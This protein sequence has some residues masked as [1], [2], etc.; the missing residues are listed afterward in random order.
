MATKNLTTP[1]STQTTNNN[2][3]SST[4]SQTTTT[5]AARTRLRVLYD[6]E[7]ETKG[8][9]VHI[10]K[11]ER[12]LLLNKT[13]NDWWQ[14]VRPDDCT[15]NY[16]GFY[17][18]ENSTFYVPSGYVV[19]EPQ[20][21]DTTRFYVDKDKMFKQE[22]SQ[23]SKDQSA[24]KEDAKEGSKDGSGSRK[25][26][27]SFRSVMRKL[28]GTSSTSNSDKDSLGSN[29]NKPAKPAKPPKGV[30]SARKNSADATDDSKSVQSKSGGS[31]SGKSKDLWEGSAFGMCFGR[32]SKNVDAQ[33]LN[34]F[35]E[36][37]E[38]ALSN[39]QSQ[40]RTIINTKSTISKS[41]D[42]ANDEREDSSKFENI[43]SKWEKV[44]ASLLK[45]P[46]GHS[47]LSKIKEDKVQKVQSE[48]SSSVENKVV[49]K[50][51][52]KEKTIEIKRL[53][54]G[55][56]DKLYSKVDK[57]SKNVVQTQP[58]EVPPRPIETLIPV[59]TAVDNSETV[60][61]VKSEPRCKTPE[62]ISKILPEPESP[63]T[64]KEAE[65][66]INDKRKM[67][68]IET[69]MSELLQSSSNSSSTTKAT[70]S[71]N[72]DVSGPNQL[73]QEL[74][75][76]NATKR[77]ENAEIQVNLL[78]DDDTKENE[79]ISGMT[80]V[81]LN[82]WKRRTKIFD[83]PLVTSKPPI[84]PT[85]KSP[86]LLDE[87]NEA[88]IL[89]DNNAAAGN[90]K[91]TMDHHH[92]VDV[93]EKP[94]YSNVSTRLKRDK[95]PCKLK[96][97]TKDFREELQLTPS[98][99][100]LAS[101]IKFLPANFN[102]AYDDAS[103][104]DDDHNDKSSPDSEYPGSCI[105]LSHD[106][107]RLYKRRSKSDSAL[108]RHHH[109]HHHQLDNNNGSNSTGRRLTSVI[110]DSS[111]SSSHQQSAS[112]VRP[113]SSHSHVE[114]SS[115]RS[116]NEQQHRNSRYQPQ[117]QQ[118][119]QS[120]RQST[121]SIS[122][123]YRPH[124]AARSCINNKLDRKSKSMGDLDC[125]DDDEMMNDDDCMMEQQTTYASYERDNKRRYKP[126]PKIRSK[127]SFR[128]LKPSLILPNASSQ[129]RLAGKPVPAKRRMIQPQTLTT[130]T[131]PPPPSQ[132]DSSYDDLSSSAELD[133]DR[134]TAPNFKS[135][136]RT[137]DSGSD[138]CLQYKAFPTARS[139][140]TTTDESAASSLVQSPISGRIYSASVVQDCS[141]LLENL[142]DLPAGW[143]QAYDDVA[144]RICFFNEQGDKWFSSSDAEGKIY[145]FE[146][147]SNQSS[148]TLPLSGRQQQLA[149]TTTTATTTNVNRD[150][151]RPKGV[152]G[153]VAD[154][155]QLFDGN[156]CILKEGIINKTKITTESGKKLRK[157]W[158][159][160]YVVLTELF[161]LFFKDAK[162][163]AAMKMDQSTG[164]KPEISV[165][166]NG[167][168][169][170]P[171]DKLSNRKNVYLINTLLGL[172]VL[173]QS[174]NASSIAEWYREILNAIQRLPFSQGYGKLSSSRE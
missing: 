71:S 37:L 94:S 26:H 63:N 137:P 16:A 166:L 58:P 164:A 102:E 62:P 104:D 11:N 68:A 83:F 5:T 152:T 84:S 39:R 87:Y 27:D 155:P 21:P 132:L 65:R 18:P 114:I 85:A 142:V 66:L 9:R 76:M 133:L 44:S 100:K 106:S 162:S 125:D 1:T 127:E 172:Q 111:S 19:E 52:T 157:A 159:N 107:L 20:L 158:C 170:E 60:P 30:K 4:D 90:N 124:V 75:E 153:V 134:S 25:G 143:R 53:S 110:A 13:N 70:E 61:S 50:T 55:T 40:K 74:H 165:D 101:E 120:A 105:T 47:F 97:P 24:A 122:H 148:W 88:N 56:I 72:S 151:L 89:N 168:F 2:A 147:N 144:K 6:F 117:Q 51:E 146:E 57:I 160:S 156:M 141:N 17:V 149:A 29:T 32:D 78:D 99:E 121:E 31:V 54:E 82:S 131:P 46:E 3:A 140:T 80:K 174:D 130:T 103:G 45:K 171:V 49:Q 95:V 12:L 41:E 42:Q 119:Q 22:S 112:I 34:P 69:L 91:A 129:E 28:S 38:N 135:L 169:I 173:I 118:Q 113:K 154:W 43:Q 108:N 145:F 150:N 79:L 128:R 8:S 36:E 98:L 126:V 59:V 81:Q 7:Y 163:F 93:R 48:A 67:W 161:L 10:V 15:P 33:M 116:T 23:D 96:M 167:A 77:Y 136:L 86:K 35:Q 64:K 115:I 138:E 139:A 109:R 92:H 123:H 14:V 73:A